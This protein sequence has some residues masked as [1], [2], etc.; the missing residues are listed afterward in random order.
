MQLEVFHPLAYLY[1][2]VIN[3][4]FL[5]WLVVVDKDDAFGPLLLW[6]FLNLIGIVL[7]TLL[8]DL[9]VFRLLGLFE[10]QRR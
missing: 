4:L 1:P 3:R 2:E 5:W 8:S 6:W 9:L 10:L 7:L